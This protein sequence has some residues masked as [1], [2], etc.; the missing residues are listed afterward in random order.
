MDVASATIDGPTGISGGGS[1]FGVKL[2]LTGLDCNAFW[3]ERGE[4]KIARKAS[5]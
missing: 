5:G 2:Y 4:R 1:G 3:T